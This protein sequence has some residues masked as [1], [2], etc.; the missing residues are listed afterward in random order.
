MPNKTEYV[1][2]EYSR[3]VSWVNEN[4]ILQYNGKYYVGLG[5]VGFID[6]VEYEYCT[7][8]SNTI[9]TAEIIARK[10]MENI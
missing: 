7:E 1:P 8:G 10:L 2:V 3:I 4:P 5:S 9:E 6:D